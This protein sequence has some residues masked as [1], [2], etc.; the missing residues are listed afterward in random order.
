M[1]INNST[2][3]RIFS[4]KIHIDPENTEDTLSIYDLLEGA[5]QFSGSVEDY[6]ES[7]DDK[8]IKF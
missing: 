7:A 5:S 2:V 3:S 4:G 8:K 1:K 6:I